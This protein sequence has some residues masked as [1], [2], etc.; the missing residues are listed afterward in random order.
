M[1][2]TFECWSCR[3]LYPI[4][5]RTLFGGLD[6][7]PDCL[8]RESVICDHCG[9]Q[10]WANETETDSN[11][12]ICIDC[13]DRH[14]IRCERCRRLIPYGEAVYLYDDEDIPYCADCAD[15][16]RDTRHCIQSY[17]YK[18][19]PVFFGTGTRC[20]G[21]ELE[22]DGGGELNRNA[23]L[24]METANREQEHIYCKHDSSL[25]DGIEAVTHPMPL[26]YHLKN[27][28]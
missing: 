17:Y 24:L 15:L 22:I 23:A 8:E 18:P 16:C 3:R 12:T 13:Y 25:D 21:V 1:R 26:E 9:K 5:I 10:V 20:F 2:E 28:P 11:L 14:Y 6:F 19:V 4:A 27:I 7:C